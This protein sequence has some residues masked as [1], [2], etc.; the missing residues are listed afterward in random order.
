MTMTAQ[1]RNARKVLERLTGGRLDDLV[2]DEE[3]FEELY[4]E[5]VDADDVVLA[6]RKVMTRLQGKLRILGS[7]VNDNDF[8]DEQGD[9]E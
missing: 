9:D 6:A 8:D 7:P 2:S 1:A 4:S 5:G 3:L